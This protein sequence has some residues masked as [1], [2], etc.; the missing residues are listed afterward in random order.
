MIDP[1]RMSV[2]ELEIGVRAVHAL[3]YRE[4]KTVA[5]LLQCNE[6]ELLRSPNFG[7]VSMGEIHRA[8]AE[9]GLYLGTCPPFQAISDVMFIEHEY[10]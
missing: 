9:L 5:E 6:A 2:D 4:L 1:Y 3:A 8:L 10:T 7:K